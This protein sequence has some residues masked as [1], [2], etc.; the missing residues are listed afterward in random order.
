MFTIDFFNRRIKCSFF[1]MSFKKRLNFLEKS[2]LKFCLESLNIIHKWV[3]MF[4]V[5]CIS[6]MSYVSHD[7]CK[8][9]KYLD[10]MNYANHGP[11]I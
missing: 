8:S 9:Q 5:I 1:K 7:L 3:E 10:F 11:K 6:F 2:A 4:P